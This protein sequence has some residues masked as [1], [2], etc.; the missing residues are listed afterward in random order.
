MELGLETDVVNADENTQL[1]QTKK[2][3]NSATVV[4]LFFHFFPVQLERHYL[5][6]ADANEALMAV[7]GRNP[8]GLGLAFWN[9]RDTT[10]IS[11]VA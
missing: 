4:V 7:W 10:G 2:S 8:L 3:R 1:V 6:C 5:I 11:C 9:K